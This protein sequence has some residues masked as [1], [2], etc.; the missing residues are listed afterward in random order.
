MT[1]L[2]KACEILEL[3]TPFDEKMLKK[4][5]HKMALRYHPDKNNDSN[6][7]DRFKEIGS[8]YTF[9]SKHL[10]SNFVEIED[11]SGYN[12]VLGSFVKFFC[13]C[14]NSDI[15]YTS[16]FMSILSKAHI[17]GNEEVLYDLCKEI[18]VTILVELYE[19][20]MKY[21]MILGVAKQFTLNLKKWIDERSMNDVYIVNPSLVDLFENNIYKLEHGEKTIYIP[22]WHSELVYECNN[23]DLVVKCIP[24]LPD[25]VNIDEMNNLHVY[26]KI[27]FDGILSIPNILFSLGGRNFN[28]PVNELYMKNSQLYYLKNCGISRINEDSVY[29]D[30]KRSHIIVHIDFI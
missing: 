14:K 21:E 22:M 18:D 4:Q 7:E 24:E 25:H 9:L 17:I 15:D 19:F 1:K 28:I 30:S 2:K 11:S 27:R 10:D 3:H 16:I 23:S 29:D 12:D 5:Y 8:S 13:N 6:A 26:L 20:L